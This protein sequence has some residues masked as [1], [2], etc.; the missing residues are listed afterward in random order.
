MPTGHLYF[1]RMLAPIGGTSIFQEHWLRSCLQTP[2]S[3]D[4][5]RQRKVLWQQLDFRLKSLYLDAPRGIQLSGTLQDEIC[6][7]PMPF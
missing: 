6:V 1:I 5:M 4:E 7:M 2:P 3:L